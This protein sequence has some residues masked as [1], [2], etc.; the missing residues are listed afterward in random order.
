MKRIFALIL[1]A[2]A[3][4]ALTAQ[5]QTAPAAPAGA[6]KVAVISFQ[7]V[8]AETNE[9]KRNYA[10]LRKKYEPKIAELKKAADEIEALT[11]QLQAQGD[12]LSEAE[13]ANRA[14][15]IEDKKKVAQRLQE[16]LQGESGEAT[17]QLFNT[18]AQKV[19]EVMV[20]LANKQG[21]TVV[22]DVT[23][24]QQQAPIV[25]WANPSVDISKAVVDAYNTKSGVPA[26]PAEPAAPKL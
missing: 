5:A 18:L 4:M 13:Q 11:K 8:V 22:L 17:Q 14:K 19:G 6:T 10:D 12:K 3:G 24:Q 23:Q 2:A 15:T 16:D 9:F 1:A 20:D 26:P 7:G 21:Y 25:L